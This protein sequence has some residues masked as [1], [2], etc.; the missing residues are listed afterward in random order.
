MSYDIHICNIYALIASLRN[1]L[2]AQLNQAYMLIF[3][4]MQGYARLTRASVIVSAVEQASQPRRGRNGH[5]DGELM[6][7]VSLLS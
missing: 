5:G 3:P 6:R 4:D 2:V 1:L 7:I